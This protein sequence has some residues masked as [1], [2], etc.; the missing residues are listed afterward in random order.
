MTANNLP[1]YAALAPPHP[2]SRPPVEDARSL[3]ASWDCP[4][5][6]R[7]HP[8]HRR[9]QNAGRPAFPETSDTA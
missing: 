1:F 9:R 3:A 7:P 2:H 4:R 5:P 6:G 8:E